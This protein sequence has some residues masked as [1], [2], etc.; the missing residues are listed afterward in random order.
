MTPLIFILFGRKDAHGVYRAPSSPMH[1]RIKLGHIS[2][3]QLSLLISNPL[4]K[5]NLTAFITLDPSGST[6]SATTFG[7]DPGQQMLVNVVKRQLMQY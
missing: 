3:M 7:H 5:D 2:K 1:F 6:H 4:M